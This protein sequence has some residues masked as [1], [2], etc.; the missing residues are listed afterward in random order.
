MLS[1]LRSEVDVD[2]D[3][4]AEIHKRL[5]ELEHRLAKLEGG[6]SPR[7][8]RRRLSQLSETERRIVS[9]VVAGRTNDEVAQQLFLSAKKVEWSLTKIYRKLSV[10]SRT[11][12]A[13]KLLPAEPR[14]DSGETPGQ[15][16]SGSPSEAQA[17]DPGGTS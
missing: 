11:E 16:L 12:L 8:A 7:G 2:P 10:R 1:G 14:G 15:T 9:L 6:D 5:D 13:A 3:E 17:E 4:L